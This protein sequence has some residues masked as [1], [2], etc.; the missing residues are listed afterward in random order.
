MDDVYKAEIEP[1]NYTSFAMRRFDEAE[2]EEL[3]LRIIDETSS[4]YELEQE[5]KSLL[6]GIADKG[7]YT[8]LY[9]WNVGST[10]QHFPARYVISALRHFDI[11]A[12]THSIGL[13]WCLG[14][15]GLKDPVVLD[16]LYSMVESSTNSE[17]WWRASFSIE[18][19]VREDPIPLLK[20]SIKS[21]GLKDI[22]YYLDNL[23]DKRSIV[24]ILLTS[25]SDNTRKKIIPL[26]TSR[27]ELSQ[28]ATE[29]AN[30]VWLIGRF[31]V[32]D[33]N[34]LDTIEGILNKTKDYELIYYTFFAI[35]ELANPHLNDL[36][37]KYADNDDPLLR[38][39]AVRGI[40]ANG[41]INDISLLEHCLMYESK[42]RVISE[43]SKSIY[44]LSNSNKRNDLQLYQKYTDIE[45]GMII[46]DSDKWYADPQIY[47]VFSYAEDP[48]NLCLKLIVEIIDKRLTEIR[49]PIDLATGTGRAY[50]YLSDNISYTGD[51]Y[52]VDR[53]SEM[54][55]FLE[56]T[57]KRK[58]SYFPGTKL[59]KTDIESMKL[60]VKSNLI[61][62]SFGFPSKISNRSR[63]LSE[64]KVVYDH[65][66]N[67]GIF[68][69]LG[70][71][72]SFNDELNH[73]WYDYIPDGIKSR[74]FEEW[75]S[76]RIKQ[77]ESPRNCDL[78]W[79]KQ[80]LVVPLQYKDLDESAKIMGY[81]FGR[82]A[83]KSI[84]DSR[85]C[86]WEMSL[87]VT[88]NTK[89]EIRNILDKNQML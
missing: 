66:D 32:L 72:E 3:A 11:Q 61:I 6:E 14:E 48:Q 15:F 52:L 57:I 75:R 80:G 42:P 30:C 81:L 44:K 84:V 89:E 31:K 86:E 69:T 59:I 26:I 79:F 43:I 34:I 19:L 18:R 13:A 63:C 83:A 1:R 56:R 78:K 77:I 27:L 36:L 25:T 12:L 46:D 16:L 71:D 51:F 35:H 4:Q 29:I 9:D 88:L 21:N 50:R 41:N 53:S 33:R 67:D 68:I 62:S 7:V 49:N 60:N 38:K 28:D 55:D 58:K 40:G 85:K 45:N 10:I 76:I 87:G 64:L 39:M 5:I 8:D 65:L 17:A 82:D 23:K 70:W 47:D 24:G 54:L 74:N 37:K 22:D 20:K 73:C 2:L